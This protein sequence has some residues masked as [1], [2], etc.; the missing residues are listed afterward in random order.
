[1]VESMLT[2][3]VIRQRSEVLDD[4]LNLMAVFG[5]TERQVFHRNTLTH[6]FHVH[7]NGIPP[8][9]LLTP[10]HLKI[11]DGVSVEVWCPWLTF[12]GQSDTVLI[13]VNDFRCVVRHDAPYPSGVHTTP[14]HGREAILTIERR[15]T[16]A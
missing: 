15:L 9:D 1:M 8:I 7:T 10:H 5:S 3:N 11:S 6:F 16:Q 4:Q 14:L 2:A 13:E 12:K